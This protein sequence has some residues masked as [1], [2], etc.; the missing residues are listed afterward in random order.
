MV[1]N[2]LTALTDLLHFHGMV[3]LTLVLVEVFTLRAINTLLL[4][5]FG[6]LLMDR[7]SKV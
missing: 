5:A 6:A 7:Y 2:D 4:Q 3:E 1:V